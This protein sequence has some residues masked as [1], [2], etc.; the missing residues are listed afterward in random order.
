MKPIAAIILML[1]FSAQ[2]F[3]KWMWV[4]DY[5]LNKDYIAKTLCIN[6]E[7]PKLHCNGKCQLAKKLAAEESSNKPSG[8][9]APKQ[10]FYSFFFKQDLQTLSVSS[11]AVRQ[12]WSAFY[13]LKPYTSPSATIFH[14]PAV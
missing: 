10:F 5:Q 9:D 1:L 7:K 11:S 14:P 2:T 6:K 12:Y 3:S 13:L 4:L 8:N